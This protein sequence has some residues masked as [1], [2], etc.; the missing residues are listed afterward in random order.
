ML[1]GNYSFLN[2]PASDLKLPPF[3]PSG[4]YR[5]DFRIFN[6]KNQT[7]AFPRVYF[8]IKAKGKNIL[9]MG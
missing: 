6:E 1:Q 8:T 4:D 3:M 5:F 9:E 7:L 2:F